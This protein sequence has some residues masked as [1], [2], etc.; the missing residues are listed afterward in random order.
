MTPCVAFRYGVLDCHG[1]HT[2]ILRIE[3]WIYSHSS[4]GGTPSTLY[5]RSAAFDAGA[6]VLEECLCITSVL[7]RLK[8]QVFTSFY[9]LRTRSQSILASIEPLGSWV[10]VSGPA[11]GA[12]VGGGRALRLLHQ[13]Q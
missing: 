8:R 4:Q 7:M 3:I 13:G 12:N 5:R 6:N 9:T 2:S 11:C 1:K 10:F